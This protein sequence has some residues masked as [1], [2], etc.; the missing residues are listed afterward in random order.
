MK[1]IN[2]TPHD[3]VV[4]LETGE[5]HTFPVSGETTRVQTHAETVGDVGGIEIVSQTY[6][7]IEGLPEPQEGVLYLVSLVVRQAAQEQ[8]RLDVISPDTS[9]AGAIRNESGQ[10]VAVKR[11]VR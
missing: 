3:V 6:G 5:E 10:I 7:E 8:G 9:P 11:F 4:R 1:I 2:L